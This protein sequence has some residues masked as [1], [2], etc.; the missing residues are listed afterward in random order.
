VP[1]TKNPGEMFTFVKLGDKRSA[2]G[3]AGESAEAEPVKEVPS[4]PFD[5]DDLLG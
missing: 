5:L 1:S 3:F 2:A 4:K